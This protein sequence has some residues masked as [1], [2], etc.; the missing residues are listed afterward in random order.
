M[1]KSDFSP[2]S[3]ELRVNSTTVNKA[4][5]LA[6]RAGLTIDEYFQKLVTVNSKNHSKPKEKSLRKRPK[7]PAIP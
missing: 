2:C 7:K 6:R 4:E 5:F 1:C 3:L